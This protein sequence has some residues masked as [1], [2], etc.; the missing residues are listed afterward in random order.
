MGG[1]QEDREEERRLLAA[2]DPAA[3]EEVVHRYRSKVHGLALSV[4]GTWRAAEAEDVVQEVFVQL[5]RS[6]P[7][8]RLE[9]G[10]GTWIYRVAFNRAVDHRRRL[11]RQG[12]LA[13]ED[14]LPEAAAPAEDPALRHEREAHLRQAVDELPDLYRASVLLF[15][16]LD[17]DVQEIADR[18]GVAPGTVKSYLFRARRIIDRK[19][20]E[21]GHAR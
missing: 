17:Y 9:S 1:V 11:E 21:K 2:G 8:L 18:L 15:Y 13:R 5:Y 7:S 20:K 12:R 16:W 6:L 14:P 10:I 4:L 3:F 19:L